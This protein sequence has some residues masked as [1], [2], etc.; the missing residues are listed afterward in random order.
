MSFS[1]SQNVRPTI[2]L[3]FQAVKVLVLG[4]KLLLLF[5]LPPVLVVICS[6]KVA[7]LACAVTRWA[8][9]VVI[10]LARLAFAVVR[11]MIAVG[12]EVVAFARF[13]SAVAVSFCISNVVT[14]SS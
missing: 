14:L 9:S 1:D 7:I 11:V 5:P 3:G 10:C 13:V 8:V 6:V 4:V 12:P 2:S